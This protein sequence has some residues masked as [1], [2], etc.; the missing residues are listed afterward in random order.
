MPNLLIYWRFLLC[1][2]CNWQG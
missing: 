1:W 2:P